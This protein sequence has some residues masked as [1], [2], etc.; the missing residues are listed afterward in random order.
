MAEND[1]PLSIENDWNLLYSTYPE[2]YHQFAVAPIISGKTSMDVFRE[3][4]TFEDKIL[5]DLGSGT[6]ASS[7]EFLKMGVKKVYGIEPESAM[8]EEARSRFSDEDNVEFLKG[9]AQQIPLDDN[10]IDIV[11]AVT[12][13]NMFN[14]TNL[15]GFAK[16]SIR[17]ATTNGIIVTVVVAPFSYGGELYDIIEDDKEFIIK[18]DELKH[19]ILADEYGFDFIDY[20]NV[21]DYKTTDY[22][23]ATYG[24]IFGKTAI[25]HIIKHEMHTI[26]W[27]WR[28][29]YKKL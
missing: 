4:T 14:R 13:A 5:A 19:T 25:D 3:L 11:A 26:K 18:A 1:Y 6:G 7:R 16:E 2:K 8:I 29:Y 17:I 9:T 12:M 21:K 23:V 24:F 20:S 15:E 10:S 22:M 28:V 27:T